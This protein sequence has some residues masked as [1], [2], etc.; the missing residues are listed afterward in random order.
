MEIVAGPGAT[1]DPAAGGALVGKFGELLRLEPDGR[2]LSKSRV[3][4]GR[5][6]IQPS[7]VA[8]G[9]RELRA[10]SRRV[11]HAPHRVLTAASRDGGTSWG[12]QTATNLPNPD[13]S[14]AASTTTAGEYLLVYN[15]AEQGR[16]RLNLA[17]S[18]DGLEWRRVADLE[19]GGTGDEYSYPFLLRADDGTYHLIYTWQ[20]RRMVHLRFNDAW[21]GA[22][23]VPGAGGAA[24]PAPGTSG[25]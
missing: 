3:S 7:L 14:V 25:P 13:A 12:P 11:G 10:F 24:T 20:R 19:S 4:S 16:G 15:D 2:I 9:E 21:L 17:L 8:S 1:R 23:Q 5:L 18:P 22:Q 6:A